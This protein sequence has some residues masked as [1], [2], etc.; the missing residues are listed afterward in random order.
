MEVLQGNC[1]CWLPL[2][3]KPKYD[4]AMVLL[5]DGSE[6]ITKVPVIGMQHQPSQE[7]FSCRDGGPLSH[8]FVLG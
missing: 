2:V 6:L 5:P 4:H 3:Q 8:Y 1:T 7:A